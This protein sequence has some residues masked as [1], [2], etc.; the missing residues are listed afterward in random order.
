MFKKSMFEL[1]YIRQNS[2]TTRCGKYRALILCRTHQLLLKYL[3]NLIIWNYQYSLFSFHSSKCSVIY[4]KLEHFTY[5]MSLW[6][7]FTFC[8]Q[9]YDCFQNCQDF[10]IQFCA[11]NKS[12]VL[13]I[14]IKYCLYII[15]C[16]SDWYW[17]L[18]I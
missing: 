12:E 3:W 4:R 17:F 14:W 1:A 10:R 8:A 9:R 5:E 7:W 15:H 2:D 11:S 16:T 18:T 13:Q 6:I